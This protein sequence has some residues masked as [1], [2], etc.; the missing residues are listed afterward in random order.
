MGVS[1]ERD[2][3]NAASNHS[4]KKEFDAEYPSSDYKCERCSS[5]GYL[6]VCWVDTK[7]NEQ[8]KRVVSGIVCCNCELGYFYLKRSEVSGRRMK[9]FADLPDN[10]VDK[11]ADT[12][13]RWRRHYRLRESALRKKIGLH[14]YDWENEQWIFPDGIGFK[15]ARLEISLNHVRAPALETREALE[16]LQQ[17]ALAAEDISD[18][19]L[20]F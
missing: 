6:P 3:R 13:F 19:D 17:T 7:R 8:G 20:P 9:S 16:Q 2:P 4:R 11:S 12:A 14:Y 1:K 5:S 10:M 18:D 15:S